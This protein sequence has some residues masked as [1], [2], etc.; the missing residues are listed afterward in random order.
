MTH[1]VYTI[2]YTGR[3]PG[4][5]KQIVEERDAMLFDIRYST[6][7]RHSRWTQPYLQAVLQD[8]YVH[9][10]ALG[11]VNYQLISPI[12]ILD[13]EVGRDQIEHCSKPVI[14]MCACE[15]YEACHRQVVADLLR[16]DGFDVQEIEFHAGQ[17]G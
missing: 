1:Q 11:N 8:R 4:E 10:R 2:G 7:S 15:K 17:T 5:I 3:T 14:L 13:Y 16:R 6:N 12:K 9:V